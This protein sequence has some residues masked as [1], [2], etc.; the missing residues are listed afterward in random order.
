MVSAKTGAGLD[1]LKFTLRDLLF[2][3][4]AEPPI[5][6]TNL[7]H[8]SALVRSEHALKRAMAS[9]SGEFAPEF[10]A[11]DLNEAREA[12]E[13]IIGVINSEDILDR[14][15]SSFCIGK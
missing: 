4:Q 11:V 8:K 2:D 7:R 13:E 3:A 15:F 10:V 12:L 5:I 9:L 6:V 14:V 1:D